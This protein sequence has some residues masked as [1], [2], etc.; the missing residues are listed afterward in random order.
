[1]SGW[2]NNGQQ[3]GSRI[4][5]SKSTDSSQPPPAAAPPIGNAG[6][7]GYGTNEQFAPQNSQ[8]PSQMIPPPQEYQQQYQ[9]YPY[10][11]FPY[12]Q[13]PYQQPA[14]KSSKGIVGLI[15]AIVILMIVVGV[16]LA[17]FLMKKDGKDSSSETLPASATFSSAE[18]PEDATDKSS[19]RTTTVPQ[20]AKTT[21]A[22]VT[23]ES[24]VLSVSISDSKF[25]ET[26][27]NGDIFY[28]YNSTVPQFEYN[29]S[30]YSKVQDKLN[31][32]FTDLQNESNW[33]KTDGFYSECTPVDPDVKDKYERESTD[34]NKYSKIH[35]SSMDYSI[36]HIDEKMCSVEIANDGYSGGAHGFAGSN[37][38]CIDLKTGD[39][40][41]LSDL[42][43]DT[44][45]F[46]EYAANYFYNEF[47][48]EYSGLS[49]WKTASLAD[50]FSVDPGSN[51]YIMD[52]QLFVFYGQYVLGS[53]ADGIQIVSI[54]L[55]ICSYYWT[56]RAADYFSS[57]TPKER[58]KFE[59]SSEAGDAN[60]A[61][62]IVVTQSTSLN[63]RKSPSTSADVVT[64]IP[65]LS[66]VGI[67]SS[68]GDWYYVSYSKDGSSEPLYGYVSKEYVAIREMLN[69]GT[70]ESKNCTV[71][72][73]TLFNC[74]NDYGEI[75]THGGDLPS[76]TLDYITGGS[77]VYVRQRLSDGLKVQALRYC[78][79]KGVTWVE[80][81]ESETNEYI[82][83][84]DS[85]YVDFY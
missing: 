50:A 74:Y 48:S 21:T 26:Y 43:K 34:Q 51:W 70:L 64:Q 59:S 55:D 42:F 32:F 85:E 5:L 80:I 38:Y 62:G 57:I 56:D 35:Y 82:G 61:V 52:D 49:G 33:T 3:Q 40:L 22:T 7:P 81:I 41:K 14:K 10:Q 30:S 78:S 71:N 17:M 2:Q 73:I 18:N 12:Q 15:I 6:L 25:S 69:G 37:F 68:S 11:Q 36:R 47:R 20:N 79:S 45:E 24:A 83:W 58:V 72:G 23:T 67:I 16:L 60:V 63:L 53:Y 54:P 9:Q 13:N 19:P 39:I 8:A 4:D 29:I 76:I 84:I 65:K 75:N 46:R 66:S 77:I 27:Y 28:T 31:K 44:D 1:M